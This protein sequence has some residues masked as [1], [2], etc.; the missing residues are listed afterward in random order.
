MLQRSNSSDHFER[1][2]FF[3]PGILPQSFAA[4]FK[5]ITLRRIDYWPP[6]VTMPPARVPEERVSD[7]ETVVTFV[8]HSTFLIQTC[9]LNLLTDPVWSQRVSPLSFVGPKRHRDPGVRFDSLP[10]IDGVLISHNHYDH[11][12]VATLRRLARRDSPTAFCPLGVGKL[13][14]KCGLNDVC[15]LDWWEQRR[16]KGAEISCVPAQHFSS[17]T[18]FDR[19]RTLWCGWVVRSGGAPIYFAGD[20]GF[21][22]HFEDITRRFPGLTI[23]LLPIAAYKPEWL[24]G[25]IHMTP[26]DAV[27]AHQTLGVQRSIACHF[28]TFALA[29]DG[30][31]EPVER[32]RAATESASLTHEFLILAE[33]ESSRWH[34]SSGELDPTDAT[35][36]TV[37]PPPLWTAKA[38]DVRLTRSRQS[39]G[40]SSTG[41][42]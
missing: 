27:R 2:R 11:L 38:H 33:G 29:D 15:E 36:S 12:D 13:L 40:K 41:H 9:G 18:P 28:R 30:M 20:T 17:R 3:N 35:G 32:L 26:E 22:K 23:A 16:W 24:M 21:G 31:E 14:A 6:F 42:T 19:N 10:P 4:F 39:Y 8:N 25:P 7:Q 5:W 1:G 37:S 34:P